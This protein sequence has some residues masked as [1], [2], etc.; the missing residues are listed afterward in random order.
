MIGPAISS[1][2]LVPFH[3]LLTILRQ[4]L[5]FLFIMKTGLDILDRCACQTWSF[6]SQYRAPDLDEEPHLGERLQEG[7]HNAQLMVRYLHL[8]SS[9]KASDLQQTAKMYRMCI[10]KAHPNKSTSGLSYL[11]EMHDMQQIRQPVLVTWCK[12]HID[13]W[14]GQSM[15]D[16]AEQYVAMFRHR[17][18]LSG[19]EVESLLLP[20]PP[21]TNQFIGSSSAT[22]H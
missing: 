19:P 13:D 18:G 5:G 16:L 8:C 15:I 11:S 3:C 4:H 12:E 6:R 1:H 21:I 20:P 17:K 22:Y 2:S 10:S 7:N 14:S 9:D